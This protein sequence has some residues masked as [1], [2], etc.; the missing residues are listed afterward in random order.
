MGLEEPVY[1]RK[2]RTRANVWAGNGT[3]D[4][5]SPS[6]EV[7]TRPQATYCAV[8]RHMSHTLSPTGPGENTYFNMS[9]TCHLCRVCRVATC[10]QDMSFDALKRHVFRRHIQLSLSTLP[11][12]NTTFLHTINF[13]RN[14]PYQ[15]L[16]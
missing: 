5:F 8:S 16:C 6:R 13:R 7:A 9:A 15:Q 3:P 10:H 2:K 11:D 14:L 4:L 1:L 12:Y